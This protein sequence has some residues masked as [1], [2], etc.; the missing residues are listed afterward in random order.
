MGILTSLQIQSFFHQTQG[1]FS[2]SWDAA[3]SPAEYDATSPLT[4]TRAPDMT[5]RWDV[6]LLTSEHSG[7][8]KLTGVPLCDANCPNK[9][10]CLPNFGS[11]G[12]EEADEAGWN[13]KRPPAVS[14]LG[15]ELW[16]NSSER[17]VR[18]CCGCKEGTREILGKQCRDINECNGWIRKWCV[19]RKWNLSR[20]NCSSCHV[21]HSA[22]TVRT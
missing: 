21:W 20:F 15:R 10:S 18:K 13:G 19:S 12:N 22:S 4:T 3:A 6:P 2:P 17:V 9:P 11:F 16:G 14:R 8:S 1:C 5:F 7:G